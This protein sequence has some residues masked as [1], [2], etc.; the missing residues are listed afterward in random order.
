MI[1]LAILAAAFWQ[2][3]RVYRIERTNPIPADVCVTLSQPVWQVVWMWFDMV[4]G[5]KGGEFWRLLGWVLNLLLW[6]FWGFVGFVKRA[7]ADPDP[8]RFSHYKVPEYWRDDEQEKPMRE[9]VMDFEISGGGFPIGFDGQLMRSEPETRADAFA[10]KQAAAITAEITPEE[11]RILTNY[12][13]PLRNI[14]LAKQ[15]KAYLQDGKS[16]YEIAALTGYAQ[17]TVKHYRL[18]F[19]RSANPSPATE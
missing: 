6:A 5:T 1:G 14:M 18:C 8:L 3:F 11:Q 7:T 15:V 2:M 10:R 12:T 19:E 4:F 9:S 16:D 13:P 17:A